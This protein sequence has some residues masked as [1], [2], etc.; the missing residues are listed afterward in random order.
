MAQSVLPVLRLVGDHDGV[1]ETGDE[2]GVAQSDAPSRSGTINVI[3]A[4]RLVVSP[5]AGG[6][7][8]RAS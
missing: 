7:P 8:S 3:G 4:F 1:A 5:L 6:S 2:L